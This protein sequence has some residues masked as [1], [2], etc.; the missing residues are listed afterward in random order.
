V[1][2]CCGCNSIPESWSFQIEPGLGGT[3]FNINRR[4]FY[5]DSHADPLNAP[6]L[7]GDQDGWFN[8]VRPVTALV[9]ADWCRH[10][11]TKAWFQLATGLS[12]E[13][14]AN[15]HGIVRVFVESTRDFSTCVYAEAQVEAF[16][17]F[18]TWGKRYHFADN[19]TRNVATYGPVFGKSTSEGTFVYTP[20]NAQDDTSY[21]AAMWPLPNALH[22]LET[23]AVGSRLTVRCGY[24]SGDTNTVLHEF[25]APESFA[26]APTIS[27][28]CHWTDIAEG[29]ATNTVACG[30][31]VA[32]GFNGNGVR[33]DWGDSLFSAIYPGAFSCPFTVPRSLFMNEESKF[34]AD[35]YRYVGLHADSYPVSV[36]FPNSASPTTSRALA[37]ARV[38]ATVTCAADSAHVFVDPEEDDDVS[39]V[40]FYAQGTTGGP[41]TSS[42]PYFL[43]RPDIMA[44]VPY[45]VAA[46]DSWHASH[47]VRRDSQLAVRHAL[48]N[49][50]LEFVEA[51]PP[52]VFEKRGILANTPN[53]FY[54]QTFWGG[55]ADKGF[56]SAPPGET[57]KIN[58]APLPNAGPQFSFSLPSDSD[59]FYLWIDEEDTYRPPALWFWNS[60]AGVHA[61]TPS[62]ESRSLFPNSY[63]KH[64]AS[65][66]HTY[67]NGIETPDFLDIEF[68]YGVGFIAGVRVGP[69]ME[70][71]WGEHQDTQCPLRKQDY[72]VAWSVETFPQLW[73]FT[74]CREMPEGSVGNGPLDIPLADSGMSTEAYDGYVRRNASQ[75]GGVQP[76]G[77][78]NPNVGADL[79]VRARVGL[80]FT[81]TQVAGFRRVREKVEPG[82]YVTGIGG[83]LAGLGNDAIPGGLAHYYDATGEVEQKG[84]H[85]CNDVACT[86]VVQDFKIPLDGDDLLSLSNGN[87]V[88]KQL[89]VGRPYEPI[90]EDEGIPP[91]GSPIYR[92]VRVRVLSS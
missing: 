15:P 35:P 66:L 76:W 3:A 50:E 33:F 79:Y 61:L 69:F 25:M 63:H 68:P 26:S 36:Q 91:L 12:F 14:Y 8:Y 52:R 39:T 5:S 87:T 57:L 37:A 11:P 83:G 43:R 16:V 89:L 90:P 47:L 56:P 22:N 19:I 49:L 70:S 48:H 32:N 81:I 85:G 62:V 65:K 71:V 13:P 38:G 27:V 72:R 31:E 29:N 9:H 82:V 53:E 75:F 64:Y 6:A 2:D 23:H 1:S 58:K 80:K 46:G 60:I 74:A 28:A 59:A 78:Y 88:T 21:I 24:L 55:Q 51:E 42:S 54:V 84:V 40:P 7:R 45:T 17:A 67:S 77:R 86:E 41:V 10:R 18:P 44:R 30:L 4:P 92:T 34:N 73:A 20:R